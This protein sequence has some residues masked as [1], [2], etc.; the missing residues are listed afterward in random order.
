MCLLDQAVYCPKGF[1]D[2][3][4]EAEVD[5]EL[6]V[7]KYSE[8]LDEL[9]AKCNMGLA[10]FITPD[11]PYSQQLTEAEN[12]TRRESFLSEAKNLDNQPV[13]PIF[14][15]GVDDAEKRLREKSY[16]VAVTGEVQ[17][18]TLAESFGQNAYLLCQQGEPVSL[19]VLLGGVS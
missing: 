11:N 13:E 15:Y 7:G 12:M 2:V 9:M 6:R 17:A 19:V 18:T 5:I 8:Q 4:I 10:A 3:H 14:G 1:D 16:L